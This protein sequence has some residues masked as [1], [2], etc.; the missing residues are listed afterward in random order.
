MV[1][2]I[3][4]PYGV[5]GWVHVTSFT[6]PGDNILTYAPW[7]RNVR[8]KWEPIGLETVRRHLDGYVACFRGVENRNAAARLNHT[9]IA[10]PRDV[11]PMPAP[12]E[13]YWRDLVGLAVTTRQ[14]AELGAVKS[15]ISTGPHDVLVVAGPEGDEHLVPF[16]EP[17][18]VE[19]DLDAGIVVDWQEEW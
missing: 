15:L 4:R 14:G 12:D 19:V 11:L 6:E 18:L 2:R 1:G 16:V 13:F 9:E 10:V 17:Y 3:G 5:R 8:G 7:L